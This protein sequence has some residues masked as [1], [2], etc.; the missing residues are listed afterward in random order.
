MT[1]RRSQTGHHVAPKQ[2]TVSFPNKTMRHHQRERCDNILTRD[3][4]ADRPRI[5]AK[6]RP[7]DSQEEG[8]EERREQRREDDWLNSP[9]SGV[10]SFRMITPRFCRTTENFERL[11]IA[12]SCCC[13]LKIFISVFCF[14]IVSAEN[15]H[16]LV[17]GVKVCFSID[18]KTVKSED[19]RV[20]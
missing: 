16:T 7:H 6:C 18:G 11:E 8:T 12:S 1:L 14:L 3:F 10:R 20:R 17:I 2:G 9:K 4:W 13:N 19:L 5:I 15:V